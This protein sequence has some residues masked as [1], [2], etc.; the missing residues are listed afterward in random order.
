M[1]QGKINIKPQTLLKFT[2]RLTQRQT[3]YKIERTQIITHK[4][5]S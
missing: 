2:K 1:T 4:T 5:H 3:H